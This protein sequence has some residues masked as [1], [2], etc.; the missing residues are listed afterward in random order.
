MKRKYLTTLAALAVMI[1]INAQQWSPSDPQATPEAKALFTRLLNLQKKG[2]MYGH[3]DDLLYGY[4][5]WNEP[6]RSDTKEITGDYPALTG[7]ELGEL[8]LGGEKSLDGVISTILWN[9]PNGFTN[10]MG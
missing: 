4:N 2:C 9:V 8:E 1:G 6:G 3:Q 10:K 5:W 7:V